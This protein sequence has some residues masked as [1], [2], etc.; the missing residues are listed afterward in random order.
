[1]SET[2][3]FRIYGEKK[4]YDQRRVIQEQ[5]A[6]PFNEPIDLLILS[7]GPGELSTWVKPTLQ[8]LRQQLGEDRDRVRISVVLSPCPNASGAEADIA[9]RY[10][11]VDR[12]QAAT[13]FW[14]F[15][16][17]GKTRENWD[18]RSR[19]IV[20][21]LGGDQLFPVLIGKRL[22]YKTVI[23]SEWEGRW[24]YWVD[25]FAVMKPSIVEATKPQ[26]RHKFTV[27]G[28][29]MTEVGV[30]VAA[31]IDATTPEIIGLLIGS[32]RAKLMQGVPIMLATADRIRAVRPQTQFVIPVAPTID[33]PELATYAQPET[34]P[35]FTLV[36][37]V[38]AKL[39]QGESNYFETEQGTRIELHQS[40]GG[41]PQYNLLKQC[42]LCLTT[43]GA[44]TAE[45]GALAVPM[46]VIMPTNQIDAMRAWDGILGVLANLPGVGSLMARGI[47]LW[48]IN[49]VGF[50]AWPNIWAGEKIVPELFGELYPPEI[51]DCILDYLT[52]PEKLAAMRS[53]LQAVRGESGA[54][55]KL[56]AIVVDLI[57]KP[58]VEDA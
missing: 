57:G 29:L 40:I 8:A 41:T 48:M 17:W 53:A 55:D 14:P 9:R 5:G 27:V 56:A 58:V 39:V 12:V 37:G 30:G 42:R 26:Y 51:A 1:V 10:P 22:G 3:H 13:D 52:H 35:G 54:A 20:I 36:D 28:D 24:P 32:K 7:N 15:L 47:N 21:F 19:G 49:R 16:L 44:N 11:E 45:L 46:V 34:N 4:I 18:W 43:A 50:L 6:V 31:A 2:G 33:L 23:Y 38:R 25:R